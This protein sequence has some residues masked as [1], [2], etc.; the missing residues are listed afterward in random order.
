VSYE[1]EIKRLSPEG[2]APPDVAEL[3]VLAEIRKRGLFD[4]PVN[5]RLL[6]PD[7]IR[8]W[9][10]PIT[11]PDLC[12]LILTPYDDAICY[13]L[14]VSP[15]DRHRW[16]YWN[17]ETNSIAYLGGT[18][19][20][21]LVAL[22]S[23]RQVWVG[24]ER[25]EHDEAERV[26]THNVELL[27]LARLA[28]GYLRVAAKSSAWSPYQGCGGWGAD[29]RRVLAL[30]FYAGAKAWTHGNLERAASEWTA[31]LLE[32]PQWGCARLGLARLAM[33]SMD[34]AKYCSLAAQILEGD[35][36]TVS[37]QN[38]FEFT[39]VYGDLWFADLRG[40]CRILTQHRAELEAGPASAGV[41]D[42]VL[43]GGFESSDAW[44]ELCLQKLRS[45][46][47]SGARLMANSGLFRRGWCKF[48]GNADWYRSCEEVL[49]ETSVALGLQNRIEVKNT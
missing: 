26:A 28:E 48:P 1:V 31:D 13:T 44:G 41:L 3:G 2:A 5:Y 21:A 24:T 29:G 16:V 46:D 12:P 20:C 45:G 34:W 35:W 9:R 18:L 38:P 49:Q 42:I 39:L 37:S 6:Q 15:G 4:D 19:S 43:G 30:S 7:E 14:P 27:R 11:D 17:R 32:D 8:K 33:E 22:A 40:M 47:F 25:L 23:F 10:R 36:R